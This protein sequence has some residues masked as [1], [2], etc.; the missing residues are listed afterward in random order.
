MARHAFWPRINQ[1]A[2]SV[3]FYLLTVFVSISLLGCTRPD[4]W[5]EGTDF[6]RPTVQDVPSGLPQTQFE[7]VF[8]KPFTQ[9]EHIGASSPGTF[10]S[11]GAQYFPMV[12]P[13]TQVDDRILGYVYRS[14]DQD[15]GHR[16]RA[17]KTLWAGFR[18]GKLVFWDYH[19]NR[20]DASGTHFNAEAVGSLK[21]GETTISQAV[22]LLGQPGT[23]F[24]AVTRPPGPPLPAVLFLQQLP[25]TS[26]G[27]RY[28]MTEDEAGN[29]QLDTTLIL[30]FDPAGKLKDTELDKREHE[31]QAFPQP[32]VPSPTTVFIPLPAGHR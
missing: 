21:K 17:F 4:P 11:V 10:M 9:Q 14:D 6:P 3:R 16:L 7:S 8:G 12:R 22:A 13:G 5:I 20:A 19:S 31:K 15:Q 25:Y 23:L 1:A 28:E 24:P 27:L 18:D 2:V 26:T 30:T 32:F 29:K